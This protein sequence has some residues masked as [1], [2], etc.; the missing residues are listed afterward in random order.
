MHYLT[1]VFK[2]LKKVT[3]EKIPISLKHMIYVLLVVIGSSLVYW[4]IDVLI[5]SLI[6]KL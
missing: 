6:G 1:R 4:G 5:T 3:W 2:T